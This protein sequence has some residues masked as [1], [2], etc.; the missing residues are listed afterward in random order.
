MDQIFNAQFGPSGPMP[1]REPLQHEA[2]DFYTLSDKTRPHN[3]MGE[4][5]A[6]ISGAKRPDVDA[7]PISVQRRGQAYLVAF[8]NAVPEPH[9][10]PAPEYV[11]QLE[12]PVTTLNGRE[13]WEAVP[14]REPTF[15]EVGKFY[16]EKER[17]NERAAMLGLMAELSGVNLFALGKM[18]LSQF[19]EGQAYLLGF[20]TYFPTWTSGNASPPM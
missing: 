4:L 10:D 12:K 5:I 3:A 17:K 2:D 11:I 14:L 16:E 6:R 15:A 19:R 20:L 13:A 8:L 18:P 1:L 7:L 9:A